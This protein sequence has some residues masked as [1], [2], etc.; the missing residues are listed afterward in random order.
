M[1]EPA[2]TLQVWRL[3]ARDVAA[4]VTAGAVTARRLRRRHDVRFV[5]LLGTA[6]AQFVPTATTPRRWAVLTCWSRAPDASV[7]ARWD[8]RADE[9]LVLSLRTLSSR[10]TWDGRAPFVPDPGPRWG[11]RIVVLTRATLRPAAA[12]RFYRSVSPV[13][14]EVR[15]APGCRAAFGIGEAPLLRQGT[16]SVWDSADAMRA[17]A[18]RSPQ[19]RRVVDVTPSRRWYA[20]EMFTSFAL[21]HAD[22]TLDGSP[23]IP[24][25]AA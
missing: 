3:P 20:E 11:G 18:Y 7:F 19:H 8:E 4:A 22:G 14:R 25:E 15:A 12:A 10:G 13:A 21:L 9:R 5:K 6:S 23:L 17:F 16:V 2:V 1:S 24:A